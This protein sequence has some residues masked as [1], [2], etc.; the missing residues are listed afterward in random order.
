MSVEGLFRLTEVA[1]LA[2]V[3]TLADHLPPGTD[4][5][6]RIKWPND[7]YAGHRKIA[8]ILIQNGLRGSR[9]AWSVV[10][11]GLN[12]NETDFPPELSGRATS[13]GLLT[14]RT[15]DRGAVLRTLLL[16]LGHHYR[17]TYTAAGRSGL[18][19]DYHARL[20]RRDRA[21]RFRATATG[22]TF[23]ATVLGVTPT[24]ELRLRRDGEVITH[25]LREIALVGGNT[26]PPPPVAE[27]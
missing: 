27:V 16:E 18:A 26:E 7:V 11:I 17:R 5:E 22:E 24:G 19:A 23:T 14:G 20:Y 3:T 25:A 6:L 9:L 13:L 21:A 8:G 12:V 4:P 15:H 1:A 10:G 2:V